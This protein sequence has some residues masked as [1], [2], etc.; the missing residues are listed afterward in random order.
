VSQFSAQRLRTY[1]DRFAGRP[2]LPLFLKFSKSCISLHNALITL[3]CDDRGRYRF[4]LTIGKIS[5]N[6]NNIFYIKYSVKGVTIFSISGPS[7][8][9]S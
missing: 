1:G 9:F 3:E 5:T 2:G 7:V 4:T 6:N 8:V